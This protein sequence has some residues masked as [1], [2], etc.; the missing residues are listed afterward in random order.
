MLKLFEFEV[1]CQDKLSGSVIDYVRSMVHY[2]F[3]C[4]RGRELRR[5][6]HEL[7]SAR[8]VSRHP[9]GGTLLDLNSI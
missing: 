1:K 7:V 4:L 8:R 2:G 3:I 9:G 5:T 6:K